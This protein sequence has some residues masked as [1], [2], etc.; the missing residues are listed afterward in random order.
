MADCMV[1]SA[2]LNPVVQAHNH[3]AASELL[4]EFDVFDTQKYCVHT[5]SR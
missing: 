4:N 2:C 3:A 1:I 5:G